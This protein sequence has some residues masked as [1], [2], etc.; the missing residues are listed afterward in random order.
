MSYTE[1]LLGTIDA[2]IAEVNEEITSLSGALLVLRTDAP[3]EAV[4]AAAPRKR[5]ARK[6][7]RRAGSAPAASRNGAA[8]AAPLAAAPVPAAAAPVPAAAAQVAK[9]A[10]RRPRRA[11]RKLDAETLESMLQGSGDGLS[12]VAIAKAASAGYNQVLELLRELERAGTIKRTGT[13]RTSLWRLIT[14]E[15]RIAERAAELA[16]RIA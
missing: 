1:Q 2:R 13:R 16:G 3:V 14:D 10:V 5:R 6:V 7:S 9:R 11:T 12:A 8:P 4:P 15:E